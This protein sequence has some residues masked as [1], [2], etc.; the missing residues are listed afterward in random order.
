[1]LHGGDAEVERDMEEAG[2]KTGD[3]ETADTAA[4]D[5]LEGA[6]R[7]EALLIAPLNSLAGDGWRCLLRLAGLSAGEEGEG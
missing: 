2:D 3:M 5:K 7:T 1:M 4:R 6:C